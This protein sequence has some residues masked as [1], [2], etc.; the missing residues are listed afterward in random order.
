MVSEHPDT[1]NPIS[2]IAVPHWQTMLQTA[3]RCYDLTHLGDLGVDMTL[4]RSKG[5]LLLELN[6]RPGVGI[7]M[8]NGV[9]LL[10][11]LQLVERHC[12]ELT[13]VEDRVAFVYEVF[14]C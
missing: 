7:Q 3:S 4:D 6:A 1:G 5:P 11:R 2:G 14:K 12:Q 9:G 10:P 8:A 13:A